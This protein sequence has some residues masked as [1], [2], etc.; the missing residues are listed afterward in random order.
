MTDVRFQDAHLASFKAVDEKPDGSLV[1]RGIG[2]N[3][4]LDREG[5]AF[6]DGAFRK[7]LSRFLSG[8]AVLCYHHK[9]DTAIGRVVD[10]KEVKGKGVEITAVVDYQEPQSPWRHIYNGVKAGRIASFSVGGIFKRD[11]HRI[12]DV[13]ILE[14]SVTPVPVGKGTD[15]SIIAGKALTEGPMSKAEEVEALRAQVQTMTKSL[16]E[17]RTTMPAGMRIA[18]KPEP[19]VRLLGS[20]S[21]LTEINEPTS[22]LSALERH[23]IEQAWVVKRNEILAAREA[24]EAKAEAAGASTLQQPPLPL[25]APD[26][27]I[28]K[29]GERVIAEISDEASQSEY[30]PEGWD[31]PEGFDAFGRPVL[32]LDNDLTVSERL[33]LENATDAEKPGVLQRIKSAVARDPHRANR[34]PLGDPAPRVTRKT[35]DSLTPEEIFAQNAEEQN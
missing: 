4:D 7:G 11:G 9:M 3:Y 31:V 35:D 30:A 27:F 32:D 5:E 34:V 10:A 1:V 17:L 22:T 13:D 20:R 6:A 15:F 18:P 33:D 26:W 8:S 16:T 21:G 29:E 19:E 28:R 12:V 23:A 25:G 24:F 2:A 14:W